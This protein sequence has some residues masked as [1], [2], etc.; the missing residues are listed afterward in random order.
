ML[1]AI[2]FMLLWRVFCG[3]ARLLKEGHPAPPSKKLKIVS[4]QNITA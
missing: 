3:G 4:A 2:G 1:A